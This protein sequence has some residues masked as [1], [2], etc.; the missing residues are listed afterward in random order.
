MN[1]NN[2]SGNKSAEKG[3]NNDPELRDNSAIQPGVSTIS[4]SKTDPDNAKVSRTAADSF[5]ED[6]EGDQDAD[7]RFDE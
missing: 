7:K 3:K 1:T 6:E 4:K 2:P 5:H